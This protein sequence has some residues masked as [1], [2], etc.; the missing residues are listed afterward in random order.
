MATPEAPQT[1]SEKASDHLESIRAWVHSNH[2][3][4]TELADEMDRRTSTKVSRQAVSKWLA[5]DPGKRQEPKFGIG[6][7]LIEAAEELMKR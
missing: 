6:L 7:I 3:K 2:G 5:A 1:S 4:I